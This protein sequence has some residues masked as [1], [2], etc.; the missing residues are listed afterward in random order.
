MHTH[1]HINTHTHLPSPVS[2]YYTWSAS[3]CRWKRRAKG[4]RDTNVIGRMRY[5]TLGPKTR[6][7]YFLRVLLAHRRGAKGFTWLRTVDGQV[8]DTFHAAAV[9]LGLAED[10]REWD[11]ALAESANC[12]S[13][14]AM[15]LLFVVILTQ[16]KP[17]D[18]LRLF[19]THWEDM[20]MDFRCV[21][22]TRIAAAAAAAAAAATTCLP[23]RAGK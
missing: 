22:R 5:I 4:R 6:E 23:A 19:D 3:N 15:R 9:L 1:A 11:R 16:E 21:R 12:R 14:V 18:A 13:P 20:S 10:D 17:L 2:R 8:C 7:L